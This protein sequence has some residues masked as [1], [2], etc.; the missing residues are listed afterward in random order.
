MSI[1]DLHYIH[2]YYIP[3]LDVVPELVLV[4]TVPLAVVLSM[5][6]AVTVMVYSV[7]ATKLVSV[8]GWGG[9]T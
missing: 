8:V 2:T 6:L 1:A 7:S 9:E 5:Y 3:L 4:V